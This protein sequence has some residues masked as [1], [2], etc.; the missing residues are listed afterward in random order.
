M[1]AQLG[2]LLQ[3]LADHGRGD[4]L[5]VVTSDHGEAFGEHELGSIQLVDHQLSVYDELLHVPLAVRWPGVMPPGHVEAADVGLRDVAP[6][7]RWALD[8]EGVP[9]L[10]SP[11]PNRTFSA[12][13]APPSNLGPVLAR[14]APAEASALSARTLRTVRRGRDKLIVPSDGPPLLF[15]VVADPAERWD[16]AAQR[17][18]HVRSLY[19]LLPPVPAAPLAGPSPSTTDALRAL[20]YVR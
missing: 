16:L 20:G 8:R 7:L 9:A 17:P 2:E 12:I 3:V 10:L 14:L 11:T 19:S 4:A 13:Y 6:L 5:V 18:E 1:D 15:D